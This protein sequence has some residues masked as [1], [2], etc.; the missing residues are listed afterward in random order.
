MSI[1]RNAILGL[2]S[3]AVLGG[4]ATAASAQ[5]PAAVAHPREAQVTTRVKTQE[6]R[7]RVAARTGEISRAKAHR[8]LIKEHRVAQ[9]ERHLARVQGHIT[10]VQQKRLDRAENHLAKR[11]PG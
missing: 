6:H 5:T 10:R 3:L 1:L 4:A 7:I 11:V 8:L 2:A 9:R